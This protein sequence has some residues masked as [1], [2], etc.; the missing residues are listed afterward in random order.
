[1]TTL[2]HNM[3]EVTHDCYSHST[4][5]GFT[6]QTNTLNKT[7]TT[8]LTCRNRFGSAT[9]S[10]GRASSKLVCKVSFL[11]CKIDSKLNDT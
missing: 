10:G 3:T 5:S 9:I 1:M 2:P 11:G 7:D 6:Q 4:H 8:T